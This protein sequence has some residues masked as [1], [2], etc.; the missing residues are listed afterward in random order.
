MAIARAAGEHSTAMSAT[1]ARLLQAAAEILG[2]EEALA[3]RLAVEPWLLEA[4]LTDRRELPDAILLRAVDI[5]LADRLA[6][7]DTKLPSVSKVADNGG[8]GSAPA[9][10]AGGTP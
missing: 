9:T 8:G 5:V 1:S 6:R 3:T 2:G 10:T 7:A 4:Y